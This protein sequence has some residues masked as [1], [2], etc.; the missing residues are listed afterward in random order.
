MLILSKDEPSAI[1]KEAAEAGIPETKVIV[2]YS[3]RNSLP[4]YISV[5]DCS[6]F[7]I[8]PTFS[9]IASSPTKHAELMGMGVPVICND[10]G[11]TG[12]IIEN[13]NTGILIREFTNQEYRLMVSKTEQLLSK[14]KAEIR[15]AA[16]DYFDLQRGV[17][18]YRQVYK[19]ALKEFSFVKAV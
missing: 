5:G 6:I 2:R 3:P 1:I 16:S 13:T 18:T 17:E 12:R 4:D 19:K 11:D 9:K 10:I 14:D 7:F 8:R 15:K